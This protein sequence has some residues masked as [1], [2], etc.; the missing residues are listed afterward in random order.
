MVFIPSRPADDFNQIPEPHQ[1]RGNPF[2]EFMRPVF[3]LP[4]ERYG[5]SPVGPLDWELDAV[6]R[7]DARIAELNKPPTPLQAI[8]EELV[9]HA[10]TAVKKVPA[11]KRATDFLAKVL[12]AGPVAEKEVMRLARLEGLS[13][14]TVKRARSKLKVKTTKK[15]RGGWLLSMTRTETGPAV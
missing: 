11:L 9:D 12:D 14:K 5:A 15:G 1:R 2:W 10:K 4:E 13:E 7:R 6:G 3:G 8:A